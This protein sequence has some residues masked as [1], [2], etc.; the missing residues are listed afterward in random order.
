MTNGELER[1]VNAK[2][3]TVGT[4]PE[5]ANAIEHTLN[6]LLYSPVSL[7]RM[8][9]ARVQDRV[10]LLTFVGEELKRE[11]SLHVQYDSGKPPGTRVMDSFLQFIERY[12]RRYP[13][14]RPEKVYETLEKVFDDIKGEMTP[15]EY[16]VA[17]V[18]NTYLRAKKMLADRAR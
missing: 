18:V 11:R 4:K 1:A 16:S 3:S 8:D 9:W 15:D 10:T 7:D 6:I 17:T 12:R 13:N 5:D 2:L 14:E